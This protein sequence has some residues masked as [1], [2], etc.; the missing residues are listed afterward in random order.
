MPVWYIPVLDLLF[1]GAVA[2]PAGRESAAFAWQ[3]IEG[4]N[5]RR[6]ETAR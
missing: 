1:I 5:G 4:G 6:G 3:S 2:P